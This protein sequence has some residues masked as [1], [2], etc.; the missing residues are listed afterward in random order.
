MF[1]ENCDICTNPKRV[2]IDKFILKNDFGILVLNNNSII[3]INNLIFS[4]KKRFSFA[5]HDHKKTIHPSLKKKIKQCLSKYLLDE[6]NL[7][8]KKDFDFFVTMN[9]CTDH[10]HI[11]ICLLP[12]VLIDQTSQ[13]TIYT[14]EMQNN[15]IQQT[16]RSKT[17][18]TR[19]AK[20][21]RW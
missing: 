14:V 21:G 8:F 6:H 12:I 11:H 9:T 15:S 17:A 16:A 1:C 19:G 5:I 3:R 20:V 2:G 10:W 13:S 4:V 7:T 18:L